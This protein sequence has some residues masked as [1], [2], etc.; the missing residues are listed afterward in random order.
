MTLDLRT[1]YGKIGEQCDKGVFRRGIHLVLANV[2]KMMCL[3][4]SGSDI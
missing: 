2:E 1:D 4:L 3:M